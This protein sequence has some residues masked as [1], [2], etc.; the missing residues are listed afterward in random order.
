MTALLSINT[1]ES[2]AAERLL[3]LLDHDEEA[4]VALVECLQ[5]ERA[6]IAAFE[7][8]QLLAV[9][10]QKS[11]LLETF[12]QEALSRRDFFREVW[13]D[14]GRALPMPESVP[15]LVEE[16]AET[17]PDHR[18]A[19]LDKASRLEVL[20]D[21]MNELHQVNAKLV[22]RSLDWMESYVSS[23]MVRGPA[24]TYNA[25]GKAVYLPSSLARHRG[26]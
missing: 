7:I 14:A 26:V 12:H 11:R 1:L 5:N 6:A 18:R 9:V 4:L 2:T 8:S 22:E 15:E 16:L 3:E 23:L 17:F 19:L 13:T 10:A 20:L 25:G 24:E 21:V